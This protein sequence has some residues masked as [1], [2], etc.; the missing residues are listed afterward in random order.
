[1]LRGKAQAWQT[2]AKNL[3]TSR[4]QVWSASGIVLTAQES[5]SGARESVKSGRAFIIS[6]QAIGFYD[7][8]AN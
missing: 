5:L 1:M 6:E 2:D 3:T 8:R 7:N 4:V